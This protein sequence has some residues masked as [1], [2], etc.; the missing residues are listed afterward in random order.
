MKS[1]TILLLFIA[2]LL[3]GCS[4]NSNKSTNDSKTNTI[5]EVEKSK[6]PNKS[7]FTKVYTLTKKDNSV[8]GDIYAK[9]VDDS[10]FTDLYIVNERD[11]LYVIKKN[12]LA[13]TKGKDIEVFN[14]GFYGYLFVLKKNDYFV[15]SYLRNKGSNISD[16]ITI[17][18]NYENNILEVQNV[19]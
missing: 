4:A 12:I 5:S 14:E 8:I 18:W 11:T 7:T 9:Y 16:D 15:L 2:L 6:L 1:I 19:P 17:E 3:L 13:N 10:V